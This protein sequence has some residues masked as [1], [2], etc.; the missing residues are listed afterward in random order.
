MGDRESSSDGLLPADG[1]W[2]HMAR[3]L[4]GTGGPRIV[5]ASMR[6]DIADGVATISWTEMHA[7][8]EVEYDAL[9]IKARRLASE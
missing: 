7:V 5:D 9:V 4:V 1:V 8:P 6:A 3:E 2:S